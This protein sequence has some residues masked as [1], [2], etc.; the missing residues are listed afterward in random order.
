[1]AEVKNEVIEE[2]DLDQYRKRFNNVQ[3]EVVKVQIFEG[4]RNT[5]VI[6]TDTDKKEY[7]YKLI[8]E[9]TK[10]YFDESL[11]MER[12]QEET[13]QVKG[14]ELD[15]FIPS[16]FGEIAV[17]LKANP[18][19]LLNVSY[20]QSALKFEESGIVVFRYFYK[21]DVETI[22]SSKIHKTDER[23]QKLIKKASES[24]ERKKGKAK[25]L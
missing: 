6:L 2:T 14:E 12:T 19:I 25:D 23:L 16:V 5:K 4:R 10:T 7:S 13:E 11:N 8:K 1:M 18:S 21:G 17:Y 20:S 24:E 9:S 3:I 22:Y 15:K